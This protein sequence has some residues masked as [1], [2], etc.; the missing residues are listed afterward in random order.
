MHAHTRFVGDFQCRK[1]CVEHPPRSQDNPVIAPFIL[2][3]KLKLK[4]RTE[5]DKI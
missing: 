5:G 4:L 3:R 2:L 1:P